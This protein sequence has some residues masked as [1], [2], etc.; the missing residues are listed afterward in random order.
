MILMS[1]ISIRKVYTQS[2][3]S[4]SPTNHQ[5]RLLFFP[6]NSRPALK[7]KVKPIH[8]QDSSQDLKN[9]KRQAKKLGNNP[10]KEQQPS[11]INQGAYLD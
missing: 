4:R 5:R 10:L 6:I 11:L 1:M 8:G 2:L 9:P 7:I 3:R